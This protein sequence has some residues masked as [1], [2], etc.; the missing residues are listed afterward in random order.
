MRRP[1]IAPSV[2]SAD[3]GR[4]ADQIARA[5][6]G[7][8]DWI[9]IDVMD[10]HFV[11]NLTFGGPIIRAVRKLSRL[12]VDVHLM[13]TQPEKYLAEYA[14]LGVSVFTFHPEA[15]IH[16]ERQLAAVRERGIRAG[17]ALNPA[18]PLSAIEEVLGDLDLVLVMS[19][20]PGFG[21]QSYW[22]PATDK[23]RRVRG[24]LDAR[25]S[26]A[27]LEVDGG[28]TPE[29]ITEPFAAG[30]EMFV[31]GTAVFGQPDPAEAVR[32][33]KAACPVGTPV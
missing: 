29:T 8:A 18:T 4:L 9:H 1:L 30:C 17:L 5:E 6:A 31:A 13:V 12:P 22:P 7:G 25:G 32:A 21:G 19:V 3:L 33:L 26:A 27:T 14:D 20:N 15:T 28:I 16:V 2:L 23:I 10:G 24:L 11:P